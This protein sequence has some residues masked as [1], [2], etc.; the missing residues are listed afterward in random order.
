MFVL[1]FFLSSFIHLWLS[2]HMHDSQ[3]NWPIGQQFSV[4]VC[5]QY[6]KSW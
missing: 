3:I 4:C 6:L 5:F 2:N 1:S